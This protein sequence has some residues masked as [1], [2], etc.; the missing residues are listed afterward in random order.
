MTK[1]NVNNSRRV[2]HHRLPVLILIA[3]PLLSGGFRDGIGD[4]QTELEPGV[5]A[6][7]GEHR[8]VDGDLFSGEKKIFFMYINNIEQQKALTSPQIDRLVIYLCNVDISM[9]I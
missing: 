7:L 6:K 1:R 5:V 2:T 8:I 3:A 4:V 9:R